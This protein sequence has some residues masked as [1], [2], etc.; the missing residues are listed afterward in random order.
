LGRVPPD[1]PVLPEI[2]ELCAQLPLALRIAAALLRHRPVWTLEY[3]ATLLRA[4][5]TR[6]SALSDG[7]RD[8][9]AIFDLSY[10]NLPHAGQL[11]FRC[12]GLIPGPDFDSYATAAL[13]GSNPSAA[14]R[15]LEHLVDHNLVIQQVPGRY[16]LHDL[17]RL[18]A[19]ALADHDLVPAR[20]A[21]L[22]RLM[23]YYQHSAGRADALISRFPRLAPVCLVPA[24]GPALPDADAGQAWLRAERPN[25]LAALRHAT[26]HARHERAV[27]LTANM[28]T[29]LR[30]D[31]PWPEALALHTGAIATAR[32]LGDRA[33][34]AAA[35][36]HLGVVR[37]LSE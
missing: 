21:A 27:A 10:R 13:T 11:M 31:G 2:I 29:L 17:I 7:E 26:S 9:G 18:H 12:L 30:N 25:L 33:G 36:I 22:N 28:A 34:E 37:N 35:L 1:D 5:Q 14:A 23:D 8:L 3:L 20:D 6:I 24:H 16:R 4:H 32:S 15:R 19:R